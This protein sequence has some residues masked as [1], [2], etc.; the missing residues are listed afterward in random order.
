MTGEFWHKTI[1]PAVLITPRR[2][3]L[4]AAK[5]ITLAAVGLVFGLAATGMAATITLPL[6]AARHIPAGVSATGIAAIIACG[7]IATALAAALGVGVG[8]IIR[9]QAA[10]ITAVLA[11]LYIA[12]PLLG[13]IPRLGT[14]IQQYGLGGLAAAATRSA[15]FPPAPTSSGN[16]Q[17]RLSWPATPPRP[18]SP[19][20][21][22]CAAATSLP[23]CASPAPGGPVGRMMAGA[24]PNRPPSAQLDL[25]AVISAIHAAQNRAL[26]AD[27]P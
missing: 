22:C 16:Q 9:N 26:R 13:F 1:T 19:V 20:P 14:A 15:G 2:T 3:P 12:E 24:G 4:L 7:A 5:L 17:P 6:L 8:A 11:L 23:D 27:P 10:A 21:R 25:S 18:C